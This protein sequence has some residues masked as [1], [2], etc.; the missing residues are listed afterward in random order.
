VRVPFNDLGPQHA[1]L[2]EEL[3]AA[4]ARVIDSAWFVLGPEVASFE[5]EFAA[6]VGCLHGVG[7]ASGTEALQLGLA[8]LGVMPGDEVITVANTAVPT[9]SAITAAGA[10]PVFVDVDPETL[11]MD[12]ARIEERI[13]ARTRAILPVHLYGLAADMDAIGAIA[14]RHGLRVLEDAAQAHGAALGDRPVGALGDACAWSFYPTKNLGALGDGGMVTTNDAEVAGR[15]RRLRAYGQADRYVH[16]DKGINSRLDEM[17]A[18]FLRAKLPHL[19]EWT[20]QRRA[21]AARYEVLRDLPGVMLPTL[22]ASDRRSVVHLYVARFARRDAMRDLLA[23]DGVGTLIHYPIPVHR[24][25]AYRECRDQAPFLPVTERAA[26]EI[27]S[28][29]LYPEM[30]EDALEYAIDRIGRHAI[31]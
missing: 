15:V 30:A 4:A 26:G 17:Q 8:A 27:L 23:A 5:R 13:T 22:V 31:A 16:R 1:A 28:L 3:M 29:P 18:A 19:A 25:E 7:V 9:V 21:L 20:A 6:S 11:L 12:P 14:H 10:Q 2:R 24:Q